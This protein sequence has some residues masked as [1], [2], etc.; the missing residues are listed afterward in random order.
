MERLK[1]Q[2][3]WLVQFDDDDDSLIG[4]VDSIADGFV[5][6]RSDGETQPTLWVNLSNVKE[7]EIFRD[8]PRGQRGHL[9]V[10]P[11]PGRGRGRPE[12]PAP[13]AADDDAGPADP[14]GGDA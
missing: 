9:S 6:L 11:L 13:R 3:V 2:K 7:I 8:E 5:A 10:V 12:E 4:I 14:K 1:G